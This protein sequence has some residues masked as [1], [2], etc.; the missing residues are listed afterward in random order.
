MTPEPVHEE[1]IDPRGN[2]IL[3]GRPGIWKLRRIIGNYF[4]KDIYIIR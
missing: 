4:L 3:K 2:E 1:L